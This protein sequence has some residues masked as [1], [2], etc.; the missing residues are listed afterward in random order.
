MSFWY[1]AWRWWVLLASGV[2]TGLL[3]YYMPCLT[4]VLAIAGLVVLVG[5]AVFGVP[6]TLYWMTKS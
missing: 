2:I 1:F 6:L 3:F 5:F 4:D